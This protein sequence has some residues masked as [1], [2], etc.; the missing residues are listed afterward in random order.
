MI[1]HAKD[2]ILGA[3]SYAIMVTTLLNLGCSFACFKIAT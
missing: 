2:S 1:V 3:H